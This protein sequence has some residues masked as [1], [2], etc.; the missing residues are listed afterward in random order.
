MCNKVREALKT[1]L[2]VYDLFDTKSLDFLARRLRNDH[3]FMSTDY[4]S[5]LN[6]LESLKNIEINRYID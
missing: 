3:A 5:K 4:P 2:F 6:V 1:I